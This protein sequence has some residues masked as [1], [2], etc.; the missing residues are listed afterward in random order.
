[1]ARYLARYGVENF[2]KMVIIS[3]PFGR[4]RDLWS[5]DMGFGPVGGKFVPEFLEEM[6]EVVLNVDLEVVNVEL[7]HIVPQ[8]EEEQV[9]Q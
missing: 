5:F 1:M 7:G 3:H 8:N 6:E 2:D 4:I 9:M